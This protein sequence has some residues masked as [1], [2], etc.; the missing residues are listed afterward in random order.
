MARPFVTLPEFS[1]QVELIQMMMFWFRWVALATGLFPLLAQAITLQDDTG[2]KVVMDAPAQRIVALAPHI[3]EVLFS[4]GAGS[5]IVGTVSFS[6]YPEAAK[7]IPQVGS[8]D[9]VNFEQVLALQP[10]IIIGWQTGNS[11]ETLEKL[12]QLA[13][14]VY[15]SEPKSLQDIARS[16]RQLGQLAGTESTANPVADHFEQELSALRQSNQ[17][18]PVISLFYQVWDNPLY[19]L[20]GPH[21]SQD[22]FELCGGRNIFADIANPSPVVTV[23]AVVTRNPQVMLTGTR[24][25]TRNIERWRSQWENWKSIDAVRNQQ[26]YQVDQDIYLRSSPRGLQGAADLC[27]ILDEARK[28]YFPEQEKRDTH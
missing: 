7:A 25:G 12:S 3:A 22:M 4:A 9:R 18:K 17:G 23:E 10:D 5:K 16:I 14:P 27:R 2:N 24:Y 19:T 8:Y 13:I 20:G 11:S 21:F 6:D 15:L 1:Q 26:L 28:I